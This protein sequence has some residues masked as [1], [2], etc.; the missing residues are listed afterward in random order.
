[1]RTTDE[2]GSGSKEDRHSHDDKHEPLK[3]DLDYSKHRFCT[4]TS[5]LEKTEWV[6]MDEI[7]DR[8]IKRG[9]L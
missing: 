4:S 2:E 9:Y 1:M 5:I 3:T 7:G 6:E 8:L